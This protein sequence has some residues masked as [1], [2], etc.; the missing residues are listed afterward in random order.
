MSDKRK[1]TLQTNQ[2]KLTLTSYETPAG[3]TR[4]EKLEGSD[5][6]TSIHENQKSGR[7][8]CI[9]DHNEDGSE[10]K[11]WYDRD[12]NFRKTEHYD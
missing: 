6:Y 11:T 12:G 3:T 5:Y 10:D 4:I 8:Y 2:G 9:H 7:D 1:I